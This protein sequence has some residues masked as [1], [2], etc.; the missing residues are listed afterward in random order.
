MSVLKEGSSGPAVIK[1]QERLK[2][3]GFDPGAIDGDFGPGT[4][5]AVMA[6]QKS[7]GLLADGIAGPR[8]LHALGQTQDNR[9]PSA[10]PRVTVAVVSKMFPATPL[11]NIKANLPVVLE[12]LEAANLADKPMVL[13]ALA[14]IRAETESF[15]PISEGRSKFNTSP[16]GHPFDLYDNRKDLGNRGRPDG[17]SFKGRG[18][19]QLTGRANYQTHG[20]AIGLGNQ[21]V[22]KPELANDPKIAAQL[23]ASFLKAKE[24]PVKE[25]LL[26][27]DLKQARKLVNG[28][29]HGLD[30]FVDAY[31]IGNRLIT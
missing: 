8:T 15:E 30:R 23:L 26:D 13:M 3:L 22:D 28:G 1:L 16:N 9:L 11:G 29:S 24:R 2:E 31:S 7:Q 6:F 20:A 5:A 12:A 14:T 10:V 19:I 4:E 21:L 18:F 25:A 17:A 27:N